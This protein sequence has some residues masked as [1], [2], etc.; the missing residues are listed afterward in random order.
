VIGRFGATTEWAWA[1][2]PTIESLEEL[3]TID[4]L[5]AKKIKNVDN[6]V[7]PALAWP[8]D[9]FVNIEE[10]IENGKAYKVR[11]GTEDAIKN[12]YTPNSPEAAIFE[13]QE[14]EQRVKRLH[15]LD[16]PEQTGK[17]PPT[18]GQWLD[19]MTRAQQRIGTPG[20]TFWAEYCAG[21]FKRFR[22]LLERRGEIEPIV[23]NSQKVSVMPF[24]PAQRAAEQ[25]EVAQFAKFMQLAGGAFPEEI[26]MITDAEA[27]ADNLA[28][29]LGVTKLWA[30]RNPAQM[31]QAIGNIKQLLGGQAPGAPDVPGQPAGGPVN[32]A[33]PAPQAPQFDFRSLKA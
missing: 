7:D 29:R 21:S 11:P 5:S 4:E 2:G 8:D 12:I 19:E 10:G 33:G 15:F 31:Q 18:L 3:R 26:K 14:L 13:A 17:T 23:V 25:Q 30:K 20:L 16:F 32:P 28:S 27:T 22:F 6:S 24:N 9:S 1:S